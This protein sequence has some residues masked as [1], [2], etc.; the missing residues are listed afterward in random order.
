MYHGKHATDKP[1]KR[2]NRRKSPSVMLISLVLLLFVVVGGTIAYVITATGRVEN[3]FTPAAVEIIATEETTVNSKSDIQFINS[4]KEDAVPVYIRATL[5]IFWTDMVNGT[6]QVIAEPAGA[7]VSDRKLLNNG[8][9]E[10]NGIYY[11]QDAVDPGFE[12]S[13]MLDKIDVVVPEGS[14]ATCHIDVRAEAIQADPADAVEDAWV[15]V[16]VSEGKLVPAGSV[17]G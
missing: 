12:T 2:V 11:Y 13:V 17:A 1:V 6:E 14:S 15:D 5:V 3:T 4:N 9:F 10:V 7:S 8:W 16:D